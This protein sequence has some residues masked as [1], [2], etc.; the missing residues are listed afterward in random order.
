MSMQLSDLVEDLKASLK[1]SAAKFD[2][3]NDADFKRL[4]AL[5]AVGFGRKRP[6]TLTGSISLI[7]GVDRYAAPADFIMQKG[8]LWG[9]EEQ[10]KYKPWDSRHPGRLPVMSVAEEE[11]SLKIFLS[12]LPSA[13]QIACIGSNYTFF[14]YA[15]HTLSEEAGKTTVRENDRDLLLLLATIHAMIELANSGT[16]NPIQLHRGMGSQSKATTASGWVE[17]LTAMYEAA[18]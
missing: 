14:Y 15:A 1:D 16:V 3:A 6:R 9:R 5:A 13:Q 11:G 2:A 4:L 8:S 18:A 17:K 7:A 10:R 12:P